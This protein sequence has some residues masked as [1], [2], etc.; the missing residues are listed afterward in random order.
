MQIDILGV[1][2]LEHTLC[3]YYAYLHS[4]SMHTVHSNN[5]A[6]KSIYNQIYTLL[7]SNC[8]YKSK[9]TSILSIQDMPTLKKVRPTSQGI[10]WR[11]IIQP[12]TAKYGR[13]ADT[14]GFITY[15]IFGQSINRLVSFCFYPS[16]SPP[17][18]RK[19]SLPLN[20]APTITARSIGTIIMREPLGPLLLAGAKSSNIS[21]QRSSVRSC[22][23][24]SFSESGASS[25]NTRSSLV[26]IP[27]THR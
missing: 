22:A 17:P 7:A 2:W 1:R 3:F 5:L 8:N 25:A 14:K 11:W 21:S 27:S 13:R 18:V 20:M 9:E 12:S 23:S 19:S 4:T 6:F 10:L 24:S 26:H 15:I 16:S